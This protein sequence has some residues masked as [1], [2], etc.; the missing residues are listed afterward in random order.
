[1]RSIDIWKHK[2]HLIKVDDAA[3]IYKYILFINAFAWLMNSTKNVQSLPPLQV[4]LN[5]NGGQINCL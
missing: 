2:I 4:D 3:H 1:M 5:W